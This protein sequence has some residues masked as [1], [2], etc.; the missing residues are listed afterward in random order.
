MARRRVL[1]GSEARS[2]QKLYELLIGTGVGIAFLG[3]A[4]T[5]YLALSEAATAPLDA[6]IAGKTFF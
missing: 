1:P 4:T 6:W 3:M 5:C 2:T